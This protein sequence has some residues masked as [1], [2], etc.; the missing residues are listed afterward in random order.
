MNILFICRYNRFRSVLSEALSKKY[1]KNKKYKV[2]SAG[3]FKGNPIDKYIK[4]IAKDLKIKIKSKPEGLSSKLL[5]WQDLIV[6]VADDVPPAIFND[7]R[8]INKVKLLKIKDSQ[9]ERG[10]KAVAKKVEFKIK[11]F[12]KELK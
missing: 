11:K 3:L 6:I 1:K 7:K 8:Y 4:D 9:G 10:A 5:S 12:V 2:K